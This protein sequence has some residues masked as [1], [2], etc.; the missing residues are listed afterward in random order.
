MVKPTKAQQWLAYAK[1]GMKEHGATE[2]GTAEHYRN[3]WAWM[4]EDSRPHT[5]DA[6]LPLLVSAARLGRDTNNLYFW[7]K[8]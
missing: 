8:S 5:P 7:V 4:S 6:L 3:I 2:S 1:A